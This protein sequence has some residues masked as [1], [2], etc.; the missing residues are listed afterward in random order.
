VTDE[1]I[2]SSS[3]ADA[4]A[5][6]VEDRGLGDQVDDRLASA[7]IVAEHRGLFDERRDVAVRN[8]VV[9]NRGFR[10][11]VLEHGARVIAQHRRL[12]D[13][14]H[15]RAADLHGIVEDGVLLD[16][17]RGVLL[18][19][20]I[21]DSRLLDVLRDE[22]E[23]GRIVEDGAVRD[24]VGDGQ[25]HGIIEHRLFFKAIDNCSHQTTPTNTGSRSTNAESSGDPTAT[26]SV[27]LMSLR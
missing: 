18:D 14:V 8:L 19:R 3:T 7:R 16:V 20:I 24:G 25:G 11:L 12:G 5:R 1:D 6:V 22:A 4:D 27:P 15:E 23:P 9:E 2:A 10:D 17:Q 26:F 21:E 13:V